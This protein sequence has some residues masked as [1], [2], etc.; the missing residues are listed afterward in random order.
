ME[1]ILPFLPTGLL[2]LGQ[3]MQKR[4][5]NVTGADDALGAAFVNMGPVVTL[6]LSNP[7]DKTTLKALKA[8]R[9]GLDEAISQLEAQKKS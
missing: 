9:A 1:W 8:A 6:A 3:R 5:S 2:I 7:D 4:D